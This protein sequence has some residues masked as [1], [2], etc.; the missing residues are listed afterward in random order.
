M[1]DKKTL[2]GLLP[3]VKEVYEK[4]ENIL[5]FIQHETGQKGNSAEAIQISYDFQTGS[6]V[7]YIKEN[8]ENVE[9]YT[10]E[11]ASI[12]NK[13]APYNSIME[14]GIGEGTTMGL[15]LPK[16]KQKAKQ[17]LGFDI[18]WSRIKLAQAFFRQQQLEST[19]FM[20]DLF[21]IPLADNSVDI[22][23]TSHSIEPNGGKEEALL[24]EL[25]RI[26]AKYLVLIEPIYELGSEQAKKRMEFHGYVKGLKATAEALG[27]KVTEYRLLDSLRQPENPS[28]LVL[29]EKQ[30]NNLA[31]TVQFIC[32]HSGK[33]M[34]K[35]S[36]CYFCPESSLAYPTISG[37]PSLLRSS[38]ILA[39]KYSESFD[40]LL[41]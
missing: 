10:D 1:Q 5:Q 12:I 34:Q 9:R 29:I 28:G 41:K 40:D 36:D 4:G 15:L 27:M 26:T 23:Y 31:E 30:T 38:A 3:A 33:K 8:K 25:Y 7:K 19:L 22:V 35:E 17:Q 11:L 32:P 21:D 13:L 37:I 20:A 16:L 18:S 24:K 6:Y 14:A 39:S 2:Y